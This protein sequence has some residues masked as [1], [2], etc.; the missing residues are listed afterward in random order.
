M[1]M[2]R[3]VK[4]LQYIHVD[5]V[6]LQLFLAVYQTRKGTMSMAISTIR[7]TKKNGK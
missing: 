2:C 3:F 6:R 1:N 5:G 7:K 4:H